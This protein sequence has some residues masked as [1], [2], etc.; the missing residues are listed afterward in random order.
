[1]FPKKLSLQPKVSREDE[2]WIHALLLAVGRRIGLAVPW[3][4]DTFRKLYLP[5][6]NTEL[7]RKARTVRDPLNL[8]AWSRSKAA[9]RGRIRVTYP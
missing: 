8:V 7:V 9:A 1:M 6:S 5:N 2:P 4:R 3:L